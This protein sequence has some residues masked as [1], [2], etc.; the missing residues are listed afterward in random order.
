MSG[1]PVHYIHG[2][3]LWDKVSSAPYLCGAMGKRATNK[4]GSVTC[5]D[6]RKIMDTP[7]SGVEPPTPIHRPARH[8]PPRMEDENGLVDGVFRFYGTH[9]D[10]GG[11]ME[12]IPMTTGNVEFEVGDTIFNL[13]HLDRMDLVRALLHDFHY[14]PE[15]GGPN[16]D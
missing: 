13:S 1:N 16:D 10:L 6:C 9:S 12:V 2:G 3:V 5:S 4:W 11:Y 7:S 8:T 14:S 15:R